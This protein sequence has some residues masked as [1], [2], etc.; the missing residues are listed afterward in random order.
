[1]TSY[2][3]LP[4]WMFVGLSVELLYRELMDPGARTA[5]EARLADPGGPRPA[6]D[7]PRSH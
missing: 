6:A 4:V 7:D 3:I 2:L 5:L 1:M